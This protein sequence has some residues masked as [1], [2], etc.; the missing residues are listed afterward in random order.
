[1]LK[2]LF[3]IGVFIITLTASG[4]GQRNNIYAEIGGAGYSMTINYERLF[5]DKILI[6]MGYGSGNGKSKYDNSID[7]R[8]SFMPL[9]VAYLMDSGSHK[10]EIGGGTTILH[11]VLEMN[12]EYIES[13]AIFLGGGYRYQIGSSGFLL[14]LKGYYLSIG[15]FSSP[16]A[17]MSVGWKF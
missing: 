6:R 11:G 13:N 2:N 12:G 9:G 3:L 7:A 14:S 5:I 1:M 8:I 17:G 10:L 15:R 4:Y 16:W